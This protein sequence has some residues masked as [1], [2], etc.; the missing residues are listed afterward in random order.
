M[1]E[2]W[3]QLPPAPCHATGRQETGGE[4]YVVEDFRY[5]PVVLEDNG[6]LRILPTPRQLVTAASV[7]ERICRA[8]GSPFA[9][10]P[11]EQV[12]VYEAAV[13]ERDD[14]AA[15]VEELEAE[16]AEAR[17]LAGTVDKV[18]SNGLMERLDARYAKKPGP[19]RPAA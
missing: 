13:A 6:Q 3:T 9:A 4:W 2:R 18:L 10:V 11:R 12:A 14:L 1:P 5:A 19:K 16:L 8:Q 17:A 15:R 7:F